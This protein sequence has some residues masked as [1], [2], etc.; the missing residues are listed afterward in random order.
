[1]DIDK[2]ALLARIE[3][4]DAERRA[5]AAELEHILAY[6]DELAA[7]D[8]EG[9]PPTTH[10]LPLPSALRAD[11]VGDVLDRDEVLAAAPAHD[12]QSFVVPKVL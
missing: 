5:F 7:V 1:M 3:L 4:G 10:P 2:V 12:G 9:V 11:R 8:T 6:V